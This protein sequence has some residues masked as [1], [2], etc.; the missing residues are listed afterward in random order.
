[1]DRY[2]IYFGQILL[3]KVNQGLGHRLEVLDIVGEKMS[4]INLLIKII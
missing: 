4:V 3:M 1:M 2:V